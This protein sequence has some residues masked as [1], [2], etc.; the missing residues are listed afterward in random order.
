MVSMR[1]LFAYFWKDQP[2]VIYFVLCCLVI[3]A[4]AYCKRYPTV[5][6]LRN[7]IVLPALLILVVFGNPVSA[8]ILVTKT[9]ETQSLRFFWLIPVSLFLAATTDVLIDF[10]PNRGIKEVMAVA[11]IPVHFLS[12][13][14]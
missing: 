7:R 10:V 3:F 13:S 1:S 12:G 9:L 6:R 8:H 2:R 14:S 11:V 5:T 4:L